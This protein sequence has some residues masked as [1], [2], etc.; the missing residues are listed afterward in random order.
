MAGAVKGRNMTK[1]KT[2]PAAGDYAA[3]ERGASLRDAAAVLGV[4]KT[5]IGYWSALAAMPE[6]DFER[7]LTDALASNPARVSARLLVTGANNEPSRKRDR[8]RTFCEC[9]HCGGLVEIEG[10]ARPGERCKRTA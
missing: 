9:P 6:T 10:G 1:R 7:R 4:S 2:R 3:L 5:E 8:V